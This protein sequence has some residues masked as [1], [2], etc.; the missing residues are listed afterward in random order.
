[1]QVDEFLRAARAFR[2]LGDAVG[3]QAIAVLCDSADVADQNP[4][5]MALVVRFLRDWQDEIEEG[6]DVA[7]DLEEQ[8]ER[9]E[10]E[11]GE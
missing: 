7:D 2:D 8:I 5:A 11:G 10:A 4:N 6:C 1:M 9:A 3:D